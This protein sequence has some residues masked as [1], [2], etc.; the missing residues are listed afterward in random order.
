MTRV[1]SRVRLTYN[2][3]YRTVKCLGDEVVGG[4]QS[5]GTQRGAK[6]AGGCGA[7]WRFRGR[8]IGYGGESTSW[9][10]T[11]NQE[12]R[13]PQPGC[14]QS[15]AS[16]VAS[17]EQQSRGDEVCCWFNSILLRGR[18][19]GIFRK[20]IFEWNLRFTCSADTEGAFN[21]SLDAFKTFHPR[22]H[23]YLVRHRHSIHKTN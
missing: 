9:S 6:S 8:E 20:N 5:R 21:I 15:L 11:G 19:T 10:G 23:L 17:D 2:F 13:Y 12:G 16:C 22:F 7:R 14:A 1:R 4:Q 18:K 3:T